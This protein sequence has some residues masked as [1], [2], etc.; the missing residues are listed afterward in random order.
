MVQLPFFGCCLFGFRCGAVKEDE[1][2]A[3][4]ARSSCA[5]P[6]AG[7]PSLRS[8]NGVI[9]HQA[10][11]TDVAAFLFALEWQRLR[12]QGDSPRLLRGA[13]A[14]PDA[15]MVGTNGEL[16]KELADAKALARDIAGAGHRR[17]ALGFGDWWKVNALLYILRHPAPHYRV[18]A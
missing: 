9:R 15:A 11:K 16:M 2:P 18:W 8:K 13:F 7:G 5:G 17:A 3:G 10:G 1:L 12:P 4:C 14:M 6:T